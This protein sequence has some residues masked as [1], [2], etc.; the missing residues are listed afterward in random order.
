VFVEL[1]NVMSVKLQKL[2]NTYTKKY[3]IA[4]ESTF[5]IIGII[6]IMWIQQ[7]RKIA[8]NNSKFV[9]AQLHLESKHKQIKYR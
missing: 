6:S 9:V 8:G 1:V 3:R 2:S 7:C 5:E 4:E